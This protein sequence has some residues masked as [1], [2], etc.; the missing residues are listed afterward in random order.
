M[1]FV[2]FF[3]VLTLL[4]VCSVNSLA[5]IIFPYPY[6]R[7]YQVTSAPSYEQKMRQYPELTY[8]YGQTYSRKNTQHYDDTG[9]TTD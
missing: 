3:V 6:Q 4:I 8:E 2:W 9:R 5:D 1:K 7:P